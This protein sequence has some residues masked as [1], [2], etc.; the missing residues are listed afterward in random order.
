MAD[1]IGDTK[2][3]F[4]E[5]DYDNVLLIN[6][7]EVYDSNN[8][9]SPRLVDHEDLVYYA[10]LETFI[11]PR[12]KLAIGESLDSAVMNTTIATIFGGDDNLKINFLQPKGKTAFDTSWSDQLTGMESRSGNGSNQRQENTVTVDGKPKFKNSIKNYEDTQLLGIKSINVK[13]KGTGVPE[14]SIQ[15]VDIQG[16]ALF[17]QGE[18]SIY[19]A[20]FNFPYPLFYLTLKGYY[21]KAIRYRLSL[22][23]FNSRFDSSTGNYDIS[24]TLIGKFTALLF[25]TPLAYSITSPSMFNTETTVSDPLTNAVTTTS[26]YK[27][28]QVLEEVYNIYKKKGL[29]D[30]N[31][32][33]LS[34][35]DFISIANNYVAKLNENIAKGGTGDFTEFN[36]V[37]DFRYNLESLKK[38]VYQNSLDKYLDKSSYY[39][40]DGLI[41][42][43]YRKQYDAQ[44]QYD[45][46]TKIDERIKYYS[47][48]LEDNTTFGKSGSKNIPVN[49]TLSD[50]VKKLNITTWL[51]NDNNVK[52][53]YYYRNGTQLD[54]NN[55]NDVVKF[56]VFKLSEEKLKLIGGKVLKPDGTIVDYEPDYFVFGDKRIAD[57][58]YESP[59]FLNEIDSALKKLNVY[60]EVI[61]KTLEKLLA[62]R[63]LKNPSDG[64]L[65]FKPTIRNIFAIIFAGADCFYRLMEDVH[66]SA[67]DVR[68]D[69]NRLLAVIPP[70]KS[71]SV[72][73]VKSLQTSSGKL[74]SDN[75]VYPWPL[76]FVNEK[77]KDG[78]DLYTIQY[79]GDSTVINTTKAY[80]YK[81]WPEIGFVE[82]YLK[83]TTETSKPTNTSTIY[84]NPTTV[85]QYV[86]SNAIEYPFKVTP[87]QDL[88]NISFF[89]EIFER[90]YLISNYG[91]LN[92]LAIKNKLD[93]FFAYAEGTNIGLSV[94]NDIPLNQLLKHYNFTYP[95][96]LAY[97]KTISNNGNG[98]SWQKYIRSLYKTEY[99]EN[100]IKTQNGVYSI[101]TLIGETYK[102]ISANN[103]NVKN[104]TDYLK[105][106]ESSKLNFLDTYPLTNLKWI[107]SNISNGKNV[108]DI[109]EFNNTT[110]TFNYLE[111]KK[112][113]G[114]VSKSE[115]FDDINL[116]T[117]YKPLTNHAQLY[118][119]NA[120][121]S[122]PI[123]SR[124]SL[125]EYY[126]Q[127]KPEDLYITE[128]YVNYGNNYNGNV[129][130]KIQT[131]SILNSPYF[132]NALMNGVSNNKSK[133]D[134]SFVALG[135]L[136]LNSLPLITTKER[137]KSSKI[138]GT[139][140]TDLDYLAST[141]KKY[142]SV[143][144]VPYAWVL[145]YGSIWHRYKQFIESDIDILSSVWKDFNYASA[146]DPKDSLITK[147][148]TF[149]D[150]LG[151][152]K[153]IVLEN[154]LSAPPIPFVGQAKLTLNVGF[155]PK[156]INAV[157]NYFFGEDLL[158]NGGTNNEF[159]DLYNDHGFKICKNSQSTTNIPYVSIQPAVL[160]LSGFTST[161][162]V[163]LLKQ[164]YYQYMDKFSSTNNPMFLLFPSMGGIP[165]DQ[166][167][168]ECFNNDNKVV[169]D[170]SGNT[171]MY[172]GS[173]RTLWA[174]SHF[175][176]FDTKLVKKPY[177]TQ[178][179]KVINTNSNTQNPFDLTNT[180]SEYSS[181]DE[182]F[183]VFTPEL[184]D[185]FEKHFITFCNYSPT[186]KDLIL[187]DEILTPSKSKSNSI[188]NTNE[189]RLFSQLKNLF[190]INKT[191]V[192]LSSEDV[193]GKI[194]GEKQIQN[195]TESISKFL[196]FDCIIKIGNPGNFDRRLFNSFSNLQEFSPTD[197]I[198]FTPYVKGTLPGDGSSTTLLDSMVAHN[199]A[200]ITLRKYIGFSTIPEVDYPN[201]V[202]PEFPSL[203]SPT[204]T[205]TTTPSPSPTP[206]Q[207][208][209]PTPTSTPIPLPTSGPIPLSSHYTF[210]S[211]CDGNTTFNVIINNLSDS[212]VVSN[213]STYIENEI[214]FLKLSDNIPNTNPQTLKLFCAR[215]ISNTATFNPPN[216]INSVGQ[217]TYYLTSDD[218]YYVNT[219]NAQ[220]E[221]VNYELYGTNCLNTIS[222]PLSLPKLTIQTITVKPKG[223]IIQSVIN[224][225]SL[226]S[227]FFIYQNVE[228]TSENIIKLYPI[229]RV[230]VQ[231][232]LENTNF[233]GF[234]FTGI[235]NNYLSEQKD[236][237]QSILNKVFSYLRTN[238]KDIVVKTQAA[239]SVTGNVGK[240]SLYNTLKGFNDKWIAGSDLKN[241][242]LFED[243]LFMDRANSDLGDVFVID[244]E[245][246][247]TRI[248]PLLNPKT[249]LMQ[250]VSTILDDN[251]FMFIAMPAYI[252]F[253]GI[254][255]AIKNGIPLE[256]STIGN[257]LFGT[258]L[259]V[260][261]TKS[262]P[263]FL[264][265][266]MG[267]PSEMPKPKEN[268]FSRFGDD[269]FDLRIPA[270]NPL[271][272]S[273]TN[274]DYSKTNK[275]VGFSVDFGIQNQNI[276]KSFDLDMSEMKNTS[277]SFKVFADIGSSVAGDQVAQQS[278][279][280][281]S[282][283]K[284][285]SYSCGVSSLGNVMIQP[286]MYFVL[287]HIPLFYG[288][289]WIYEVNHSVDESGFKTDFKGTRIPKYS[290]PNVNELIINVNKNILNSWKDEIEKS[291][292]PRFS[293]ETLINADPNVPPIILSSED[294]CL[295]NSEYKKI[296]FVSI[297]RTPINF[298]DLVSEIK[299]KPISRQM[300][301]LILGIATTR[302][303]NSFEIDG[304]VLNVINY[305][306]YEISADSR[307]PGSLDSYISEQVCAKIGGKD[308]PLVSFSSLTDS[309][310]FII[311]FYSSYETM[312]SNLVTANTDTDINKSYGKSLAQ[313][314][315]TT[316]DTAAAFGDTTK[317][318]PTPPLTAIQ[319]KDFTLNAKN[320]SKFTEYDT[321]VEIFTKYYKAFI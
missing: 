258:Y 57:G 184:L 67:W 154:F 318:P 274:R 303:I 77:Q 74:N 163:T 233:Y 242:T 295:T 42:Y 36:D 5:T 91:K 218:D 155:Y 191:G 251:K 284:S 73:A 149:P 84:N 96:F 152:E 194:L 25:D 48:L 293:G 143:H 33:P 220:S 32:P 139:S 260:D 239:S 270:D 308:V 24:L 7:N 317:S 159:I 272:V 31:F 64:G 267:N 97:M 256:D 107:S 298:T 210:E 44:F 119:T 146:Y 282:I 94:F 75:V 72:D 283:Y 52:E 132:I 280:M 195:F 306:P 133:L 193:D 313:L 117:S 288:P 157:N 156:V 249:N 17:E 50:V 105:N 30:D 281:Y 186:T 235:I 225:K 296:P 170:I 71:F 13:I 122:S 145:K 229:I 135:Y 60:D 103:P 78:R 112:T 187:K 86:S 263:K 23:T 37:A 287:R 180:Q 216:N 123:I 300:K 16:R 35:K 245:K 14:V 140:V 126:D 304:E 169:K 285:R 252:N 66:K 137:L 305:N 255:K 21:G 90:S 261:Y 172:N 148:Y 83:G 206:S 61:T 248:D 6:P 215:K 49:I 237:Q 8:L 3:I 299:N 312:I 234:D 174:S 227:E 45:Y 301:A 162:T 151:N 26:S 302:P 271:R 62:D 294:A 208:P 93:D 290:L 109:E 228:F 22:V 19:S 262:S 27:G 118:L 259:E 59:S 257:S 128:S 38:Y 183:S 142:S 51:S 244:V 9:R 82:A 207:T 1:R 297:E 266:Y 269:S 99:I 179:L 222:P 69:P 40:N 20:F 11:V 58:T 100:L 316:W 289:Y 320:D 111:S 178:Y 209:G 113:I 176:Y 165:I 81:I 199:D 241:M 53:T 238:L 12:T 203:P 68:D 89:Y 192:T 166:S 246:V 196:S 92:K 130:S 164:N 273:D 265:L 167:I 221:C 41:Y 278:V 158:I 160:N 177:P 171:A 276:F 47:K 56:S 46:N 4:I 286:T 190:F 315:F 134:N 277:E 224:Q 65:G 264:C 231:K 131:T 129:N 106:T 247:I 214:Y 250:V 197:K 85:S 204:P 181:I 116:L 236:L 319:I 2:K 230:Y 95:T 254:Q 79:P 102:N 125:K 98:E 150:Y 232:R 173:V 28:R 198:T 168:Y 189:K 18:S 127:R 108:T 243:F 136:F 76:Y 34:I 268:S 200:W 182:I 223:P 153:K 226:V 101:D 87:Y 219:P 310:N 144:Q 63:Q 275:V 309:T 161:D 70:N 80:D 54:L 43:P 15:M 114:R 141:L 138:G 120:T 314:T 147:T 29:I 115:T 307:Q 104:L 124:L 212:M 217:Q 110:K 311:S 201:Q 321:Y 211:C 188:K 10:N 185:Q 253:Y 39:V 213:N 121:N 55:P 205:P 292:A 202:I 175:G 240:L 279:S 291:R 88:N